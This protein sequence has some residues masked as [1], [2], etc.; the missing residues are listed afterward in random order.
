MN[1]GSHDKN[2]DDGQ[3]RSDEPNDADYKPS[4][5]NP[6]TTLCSK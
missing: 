3:C 6:I 2:E 1:G 5:G 4:N